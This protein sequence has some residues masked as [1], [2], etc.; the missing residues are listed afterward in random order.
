MLTQL[1]LSMLDCIAVP[2]G[3]LALVVPWRLPFMV[4]EYCKIVKESFGDSTSESKNG[5]FNSFELRNEMC[6][7]VLNG[8]H[9]RPFRTNG[10]LAAVETLLCDA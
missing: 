4:C 2:L 8:L 5:Y 9:D 3:L 7:Q 1:R 6:V 10:T